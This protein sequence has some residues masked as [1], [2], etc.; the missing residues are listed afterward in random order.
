MPENSTDD[1]FSIV[2]PD[3]PKASA[4]GGFSRLK[5]P[6]SVPAQPLPPT[7]ASVSTDRQTLDRRVVCPLSALADVS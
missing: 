4:T 7:T 2:N 3:R 5:R 1:R 6:F